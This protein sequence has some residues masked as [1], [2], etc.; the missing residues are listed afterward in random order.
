MLAR[1]ARTRHGGAAEGKRVSEAM[2]Q[3]RV[4]VVDDDEAVGELLSIVL[5]REGLD[6]DVCGDGR[7]ALSALRSAAYDLVLTD[8]TMPGM[9]GVDLVAAARAQG[10]RVPFLVMSAWVDPA[11][12]GELRRTPGVV[13][14][15]RKPFDIAHIGASVRAA[16]S[17]GGVLASSP[18]EARDDA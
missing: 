3:A 16:L 6:A 14:V 17:S 9:S 5:R 15:L 11:R 1:I 2:V 12:E 13:A 10:A 4:L 18:G 7:A 8:V